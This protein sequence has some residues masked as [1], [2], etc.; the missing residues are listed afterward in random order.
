MKC[1]EHG[2]DSETVKTT[3]DQFGVILKD[4]KALLSGAK[5]V[6]GE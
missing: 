4:V 2:V 3:Y 6:P 5:A 1:P